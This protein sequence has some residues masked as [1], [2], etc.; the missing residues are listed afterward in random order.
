MKNPLTILSLIFI[1]ITLSSCNKPWD[2]NPSDNKTNT[3][4]SI[5]NP[6]S[7][8]CLQQW[9]K[10]EKRVLKYWGEYDAC[11]LKD[12][13]IVDEWEYFRKNTKK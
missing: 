10:R 5:A 9:W 2:K 7:T 3:P 11:I 12:G 1:V 13:T 4:V 6:A 8:Y